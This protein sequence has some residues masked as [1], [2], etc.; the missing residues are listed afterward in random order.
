MGI[1]KNVIRTKI[2]DVDIVIT[3]NNIHIHNSYEIIYSWYMKHIL[4]TLE[5]YLKESNITMDNPLN[6]RSK[7]SMI[8]EWIAHNN[9]YNIGIMRDRTAY[10]DLNFPQKWYMKVLYF[11]CSLVIL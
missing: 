7:W 1:R 6:H 5:K 10:V 2:E 11:M 3:E 9:A 4:D 8:R